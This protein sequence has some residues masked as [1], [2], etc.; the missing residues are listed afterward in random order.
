MKF[1]EFREEALGRVGWL[2]GG[3]RLQTEE[4]IA[5]FPSRYKFVDL[6]HMGSREALRALVR[7]WCRGSEF[8]TD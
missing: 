4:A 6:N 3:S 1:G 5:L 7:C 2:R 8:P